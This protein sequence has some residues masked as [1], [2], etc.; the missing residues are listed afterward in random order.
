MSGNVKFSLAFNRRYRLNP[1]RGTDTLQ[2]Y[3]NTYQNTVSSCNK[4][5]DDQELMEHMSI[6]LRDHLTAN[7]QRLVAKHNQESIRMLAA[8]HPDITGEL[9]AGLA[10]D[11]NKTVRLAAATN[12]NMPQAMLLLLAMDVDDNVRS[13]ASLRLRAP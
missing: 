13:A 1:T 9:L 5:Q 8:R 4:Q 3:P 2:N 10:S 12:P 6:V 11:S 7:E